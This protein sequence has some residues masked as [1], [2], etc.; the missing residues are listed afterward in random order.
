MR[1]VSVWAAAALAACAGSSAAAEGFTPHLGVY[2]LSLTQARHSARISGA[3]GRFVISVEDV[4]EGF[5]LNEQLSMT[6]TSSELGGM[7]THYRRSAYEA[8][9]GDRYRFAI[10]T[11]YEQGESIMSVGEAA[12]GA[13]G[14]VHA[15]Y[16]TPAELGAVDSPEGGIWPIMHLSRVI[17]AAKAGERVFRARVF[18]GDAEIPTLDAVARIG[19]ELPKDGAIPALAALR[20]WPVDI[21]YFEPEAA[22]SPPVYSL[23]TVLY[24]NGAQGDMDLDFGDFQ[25]K[26][27]LSRF[28]LREPGC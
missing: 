4:C 28:E 24:E 11:R 26:A 17:A 22:D 1:A 20:R 12:R 25:V 5:T 21:A 27:A 13:D 15:V 10:E 16:D 14:A 3:A 6:L 8:K 23:R 18:D 9:D 7:E 2:D 19:G